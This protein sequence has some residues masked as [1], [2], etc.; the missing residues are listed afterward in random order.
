MLTTMQPILI[1]G[2]GLAGVTLARILT[3]HGIPN[4]VFEASGPERS[5]GFAISLRKWAYEPLLASLGHLPVRQLTRA[6]ALDRARG[7]HGWLDLALRN[8]ATGDV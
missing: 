6:V 3:A 5:Q 4:I 2:A 1:I 7:G 8:N